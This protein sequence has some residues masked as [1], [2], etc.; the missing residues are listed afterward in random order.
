MEV[1]EPEFT[2]REPWA[3]DVDELEGA[4]EFF[5]LEEDA[6]RSPG[7]LAMKLAMMLADDDELN[8]DE[9]AP[10]FAASIP[11]HPDTVSSLAAALI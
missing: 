9:L 4:R 8:D 1:G 6:E 5:V 11:G 2:D 10:P 3:V 7:V